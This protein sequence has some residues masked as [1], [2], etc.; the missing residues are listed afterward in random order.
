[1]GDAGGFS[2]LYVRPLGG[3]DETLFFYV[4]FVSVSGK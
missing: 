2:R 1:M 4:E 3:L